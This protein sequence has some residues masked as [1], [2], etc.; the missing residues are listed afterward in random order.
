V[1]YAFDQLTLHQFRGIQ[2]LEL[3]GLGRFNL[4]VGKNN[5]GKTSVLEALAL[6]CSPLDLGTWVNAARRREPPPHSRLHP[7]RQ[8]RWLFTQRPDLVRDTPYVGDIRLSAS[9][10]FEIREMRAHLEEIR[11]IVVRPDEELQGYV[12]TG[13]LASGSRL[14]V[15]VQMESATAPGQL[16][17]LVHPF[18][19]MESGETRVPTI[20][21][22]PEAKARVIAPYAHWIIPLEGLFS[23][24][25]RQGHREAAVEL[26][27]SLGI[28]V[29]HAE[30]FSD[31][32]VPVLYLQD[33]KAGFLPVSSF[34]DG[35]RRAL[36]L[37]LA[38]P[39]A[40]K[41]VLLIDELETAIHISMLGKVFNW[42]L[43]ACHEHDVQVVATTH[44]LEAIDAIL[45]ADTT[46]REDIV[47]FRME[48][49]GGRMGVKR[50]GEETLKHLRNEMGLDVR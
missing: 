7:A 30:V 25:V 20:E 28:R 8:L 40:A 5:S 42:V 38:I 27:R 2:E 23:E 34:G 15:H 33:S 16:R 50:F 43:A 14:E 13:D 26:M 1:S 45:G 9:G 39:L 31:A 36:L 21:G 11:A 32:G 22:A 47:A 10:A 29:E 44:S 3:S 18:T 4:L 49:A 12:T 46:P 35:V 6:Y 19:L 41:G 37:A 24:A 48:R 17:E